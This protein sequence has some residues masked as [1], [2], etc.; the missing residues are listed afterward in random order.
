MVDDVIYKSNQRRKMTSRKLPKRLFIGVCLA[1]AWFSVAVQSSNAL[2][3]DSVTLTGNTITT[4]TVDLLISNSQN[5]SS[6]IYS[7]TRTG[8]SLVMSPGESQE[9]YIILKNASNSTL[10]MDIDV[11]A[12]I[13]SGT[14]GDIFQNVQI[15]FLPV[16]STGLAM[17]NSV[18]GTINSI[19]NQRLRLGISIPQDSTQRFRIRTSL[20]A[21][22]NQQN[23]NASYDLIFYGTQ[24][25]VS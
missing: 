23:Q 18:N 25:V 17:G 24:T 15:E 21:N 19:S 13:Q 7:D 10:A 6:T 12:M 5:S 11:Q 8:F 16:D 4:G 20:N 1:L 14:I 2:F 9:R 22:Y 3:N